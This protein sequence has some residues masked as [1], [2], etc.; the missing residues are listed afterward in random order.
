[1]DKSV[2]KVYE[3]EKL[4]NIM[5]PTFINSNSYFFKFSENEYFYQYRRYHRIS[6]KIFYKYFN[7]AVNN[8]IQRLTEQKAESFSRLKG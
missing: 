6:K 1:M 4:K 8:W 3:N 2:I 7:N 5:I